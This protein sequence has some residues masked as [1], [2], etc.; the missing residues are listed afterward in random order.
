MIK[1]TFYKDS[2][3][4]YLGFRFRGH[5][6]YAEAGHDIVCAAVSALCINTVNSIEAFTEDA[7]RVEADEKAGMLRLK[8]MD[9]ASRESRLLMD[10]LKLGLEGIERDNNAEYISVTTKEV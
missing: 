9:T 5:A 8:F 7:V 4:G 1:V 6:G 3:G 10:S 2:D